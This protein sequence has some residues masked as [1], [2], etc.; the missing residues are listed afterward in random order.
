MDEESA[1]TVFRIGHE[2]HRLPDYAVPDY[3]SLVKELAKPGV[4][5]QLLFEEYQDSCRLAGKQAYQKT[6][7]RKHLNDYLNKSEFR[8]IMTHKAGERIEVDWA[9]IRPHWTDPDTGEIIYGWLFGGILPFSGLGFAC[10]T[11]DMKMESWIECH[12]KMFTYFGGSARILTPDNLKTG[13]T[14]HGRDEIIV[15]RTYQEMADYYSTVV[16]PTGVRAPRGKSNVEHLMYS[17]ENTIIG[18]LRNYQFFSIDEYN[19]AAMKEVERFN[20]KP[21]Q[22]KKGTRRQ[23]FEEFEKNALTPLPAMPYELASWRK[24]K[25]QNNS[26]IVYAKN[27][28]SVPYE[29]IGNEVDVRITS[30][31]L[32][33]YCNRKLL[34]SHRLQKGRVGAYKTD[35]CHMPPN[36]NAYGEWNSTRYLNWA[37]TKGDHVYRL[38]KKLFDSTGTEQR[39]YRTVHSILKLA[40]RYSNERLN[41]ACRYILDTV[42]IPT[43]RGVKYVLDTGKDLQQKHEDEESETSWSFVRGG[44]YFG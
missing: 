12:V 3:S 10:I 40:D 24:A 5:V 27:Y 17:F 30:T 16:I 41:Q 35:P 7:F 9:G 37:K 11:P 4:T 22:K 14:R 32:K 2:Q 8:D 23:V 34:C 20:N 25:V 1:K 26:H 21:F 36:S 43:Y 13:I 38:V 15:N 33:V 19:E 31:D 39:Y 29:Y 18:R 42:S 6:Q 28:Y 44:D